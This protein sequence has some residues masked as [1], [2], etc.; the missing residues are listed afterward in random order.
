MTSDFEA[1]VPV[2]TY[3]VACAALILLT[4]LNIGLAMMVK[5]NAVVLAA[6]AA[7]MVRP[8]RKPSLLKSSCIS[9]NW[10]EPEA[11]E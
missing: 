11:L 10:T 8:E 4:L 5:L 3:V 9:M 1:I 2:R 6:S 7:V